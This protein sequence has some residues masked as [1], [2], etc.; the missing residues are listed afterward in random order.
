MSV[1]IPALDKDGER[2]KVKPNTVSFALLVIAVFD[3][4]FDLQGF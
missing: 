3:L 4:M 1:V 2:M